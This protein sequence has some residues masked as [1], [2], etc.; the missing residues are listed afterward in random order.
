MEVLYRGNPSKF[1]MFKD[2]THVGVCRLCGDHIMRNGGSSV[3]WSLT[4]LNGFICEYSKNH[5]KQY[6]L[7]DGSNS[8]KPYTKN[9]VLKDYFR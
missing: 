2:L 1:R 7:G 3:W 6:I 4:G 8:H 5:H 9:D